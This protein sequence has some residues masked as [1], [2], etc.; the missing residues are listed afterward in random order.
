MPPTT[1]ATLATAALLGR[2]F[3]LARVLEVCDSREHVLEALEHAEHGRLIRPL[4]DA[5]GA[6][7][8]AHALVRPALVEELA[9][10]ERLRLHERI[11][12]RLEKNRLVAAAELARHFCE[13]APLG[14]DGEAAHWSLA[15]AD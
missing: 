5:S 13:A 6:F 12:S 9:A 10:A 8:F 4:P 15:A 3:D 14:H 2:E 11:A 1:G 7:A